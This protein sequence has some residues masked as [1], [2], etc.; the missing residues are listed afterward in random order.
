M[1]GKKPIPL[2]KQVPPCYA[3][4]SEP[5]IVRFTDTFLALEL[6]EPYLMEASMIASMTGIYPIR[7]VLEIMKAFFHPITLSFRRC[8]QIVVIL[9]HPTP[10][11]ASPTP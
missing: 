2:I 3:Q 4:L 1:I 8:G 7:L 10:A 9:L 5:W 6:D 11:S